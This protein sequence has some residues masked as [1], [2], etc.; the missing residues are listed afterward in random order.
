MQG[1]HGAAATGLA[2]CAG[3]VTLALTQSCCIVAVHLLGLHCSSK[4]DL[5]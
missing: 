4:K 5:E 2:L 3:P 1:V